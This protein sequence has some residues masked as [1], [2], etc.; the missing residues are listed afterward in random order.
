MR[1]T[2]LLSIGIAS[3]LSGGEARPPDVRTT[4]FAERVAADPVRQRAATKQLAFPLISTLS[5]VPDPLVVEAGQQPQ[6]PWPDPAA[7]IWRR[8]PWLPR[9]DDYLA[10]R[11]E[12]SKPEQVFTRV[13]WCE[14]QGLDDCAA[15]E[16][17]CAFKPMFMD[18]MNPAYQ[19]LNTRWLK[20]AGRFQT[21]WAFPL[22]FAGTWRVVVDQTGHHRIK[23]GATFAF[24]AIVEQAGR[25]FTGNGR[26]LTDH[27]TFGREILAQADG[28][29][30]VAEDANPDQPVGQ[31][32]GYGGANNVIVDYGG[33]VRGLYGHLQQKSLTVKVGDRVKPG[34][35]LGKTGNSGAS[36]QP[37]LHW[38]F[39][40]HDHISIVGNYRFE[41]ERAGRWTLCESGPLPEGALVRNPSSETSKP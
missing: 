34:Q 1:L 2:A 16:L 19:R 20:Y 27:H 17:R 6:T 39:V 36:G 40:D 25:A 37:H 38:T 18:F 24:D 28:V 3:A 8:L 13:D 33:G 11:K 7:A 5:H 12:S 9:F 23:A 22:P 35:V 14:K 26:A 30:I 15:F 10:K 21:P 29:V 31:A 4:T 41:V 32:G